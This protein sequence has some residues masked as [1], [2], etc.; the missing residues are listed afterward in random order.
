MAAITPVAPM[1]KKPTYQLPNFGF[2]YFDKPTPSV[3]VRE[4][5]DFTFPPVFRSIQPA[6][7]SQSP[8]SKPTTRPR[9][10]P[11]FSLP[12][13]RPTQYNSQ[14]T[15]TVV[16]REISQ[17]DSSFLALPLEIR[18]KIYSHLISTHSA[19]HPHLAPTREPISSRPLPA[20]SPPGRSNPLISSY[21]QCTSDTTTLIT[22]IITPDNN[23][24]PY[25]EYGE[26]VGYIP[27]ALLRSCRQI[28]HEA[29][30]LPFQTCEF[31]FINYFHSGMFS[32]R[33]FLCSLAPWQR[34]AIRW[35]GIEVLGRDFI[36]LGVGAGLRGTE[37]V[38]GEWRD[39]TDGLKGVWGL[40]L[41]VR[42]RVGGPIVGMQAI[43]DTDKMSME[44]TEDVGDVVA[45]P[46]VLDIEAEWVQ[47][48]C[49]LKQLRWL[50]IEIGDDNCPRD[51]KVQF[52][53]DLGQLLHGVRV[54]L[55]ERI[56]TK[57]DIVTHMVFGEPDPELTS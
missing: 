42:G 11:S 22:T 41:G 46:G 26:Y 33:S 47:K 23:R 20:L 2:K 52:C 24:L 15:P 18:L 12:N 8:S 45:T 27:S 50:E 53:T 10:P 7:R 16:A 3:T 17:N 6:S 4:L 48:L 51:D 54:L 57:P 31:T 36:G 56:E 14:V 34:E 1:A 19:M 9:T 13:S 39:I 35:A 44:A 49:T 55:I 37:R 43:S 25:S 28:Y 32:A 21:S 38:K 29:R 30:A 5:P 40:R